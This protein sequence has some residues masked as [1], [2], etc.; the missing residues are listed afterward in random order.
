MDGGSP[1]KRKRLEK[2]LGQYHLA[3]DDGRGDCHKRACI[4]NQELS[5]PGQGVR[6]VRQLMVDARN[7]SVQSPQTAHPALFGTTSELSVTSCKHEYSK[8]ILPEQVCFG[9][10]RVI[11]SC[12]LLPPVTSSTPI[13]ASS[14]YVY[15]L[16][17]F[18]FFGFKPTE[19]K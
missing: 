4:A 9:M 16:I 5:D 14:L 2:V 11:T 7:G 1:R 6:G 13:D 8:N 15:S 3:K 10:V 17:A 19:S 12:Q 18:L